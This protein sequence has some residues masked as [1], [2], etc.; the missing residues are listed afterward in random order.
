MYCRN[1]NNT[2]IPNYNLKYKHTIYASSSPTGHILN[3]NKIINIVFFWFF[4]N[5]SMIFKDE[6]SDT[7]LEIP[8]NIQSL[9]NATLLTSDGKNSAVLPQNLCTYTCIFFCIQ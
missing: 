8:T 4:F 1:I 6:C 3:C 2:Y 7:H 5:L 9:L